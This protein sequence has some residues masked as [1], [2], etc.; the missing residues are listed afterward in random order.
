M[1]PTR[2]TVEEAKNRMDRGEPLTFIDSRNPDAWAKT[3]VKLP[4][5]IRIPA[6]DVAKHLSEIPR[7]RAI[8][9]YCT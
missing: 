5:A 7:D 3:S 4:G 2:I 6:E 9:T 8:L 1:Q